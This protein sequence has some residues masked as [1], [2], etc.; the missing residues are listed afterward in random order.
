[1]RG[2]QVSIDFSPP[3]YRAASSDLTISIS[4]LGLVELA[5]EEFEVHG[6][7]LN[8]YSLNWAMYLG[9]HT[10]FRR[11]QGEPQMVFNYYRAIT[12]FIIN[13]TFS[14]G[15]QFRSPKA[16]EAIVPDLLERVWEVD[17]NKATVLWE[18]GQQGSVSG[19]CF[20][21]VAYE[22]AWVDPAGMQHPGRVRVLPLNSSFCFPE[23]HPHDRNRLIRFKLKYRFWG[24]SLEGTRQVY[25]YTE[26]LTDDVIEEYINDE[27]IDSRPNP[28]G[29]IPVVH[30]P[31]IRISGSPWGLSDCNE[32]ISLN[33]AYNETATDIADIINYHAAPVTVIIGAKASQLEKGA[34]KVWGG[35]PKDARV[36]NLEGGGQG[37]KGAMEYMTMLKRAM[38]EMTGVPETALGQSQPI[39]NTSGVALAI[40]FQ[41]LMNRYHQKIVQYAY[42]LER[43]NELILRNLAV[44]EPE[45]FTWNPDRDTIPK[46]D[47]LLQLDPNDPDT[48][49]TYVHFPPPLPLDKLIILNEIQSMLSLGLESKE[50]A[51]RALGEE[52][53]SEKIQEIRQELIDDAKADGAL[54]LVQTEIAN[55]IMTLT[56]MVP[57]PDGSAAPLSPEQAA[58]MAAG[59][60]S[61]AQTPLLDGNVVQ[62]LQLGEQDIRSRLVTEA[63]GTKIPQRRVPEEYEK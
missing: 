43:V 14:K 31:N 21:K 8:R 41:P 7:R 60:G 63:Y 51:L 25:T 5:D 34:N 38:H 3:S 57:G 55:E 22:E 33:R 20:V 2:F 12:D 13:F 27:L 9:H 46:P 11:Q 29:T 17:N 18:I 30:M 61:P 44:K 36:E 59:G 35:L 39:S 47:Q 45:T 15:V 10:S 37:L 62:G 40:Q 52:F 6:P 28:L 19:D 24:T 54:K 32:M 49:R 56:G 53:P 1:M 42:G 50:G 4:P 26:I 48:Y 23:F 16:T 58:G